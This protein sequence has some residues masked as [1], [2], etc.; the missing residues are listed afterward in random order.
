MC[1][2]DNGHRVLPGSGGNSGADRADAVGQFLAVVGEAGAANL[3]QF[4]EQ[5]RQGGDAAGRRGGQIWS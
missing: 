5:G 1:R 3:R 2:D 4:G